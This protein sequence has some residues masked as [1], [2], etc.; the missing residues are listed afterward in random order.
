VYIAGTTAPNKRGKEMNFKFIHAADL[1]LDSPL[2]G[3]A[4]KSADFHER[5]D[6]ASRQAFDG[7]VDLAIQEQC[8]FVLLAGDI[9]DGEWKDYSTG[10][11]FADR[12][13]RLNDAEIKVFAVFGN[14]DAENRFAKTT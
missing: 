8:A 7:L 11:F 3:L 4:K 12:M 13:R 14:H 5:I 1:H 9:F 2:R 10:L 6:D